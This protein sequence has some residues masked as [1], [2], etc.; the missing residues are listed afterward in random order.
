MAQHALEVD[1]RAVAAQQHQRRD[2]VSREREQPDGQ[3]A[4]GRDVGRARQ[5]RDSAHED[6]YGHDDE[7]DAI[8]QCGE[9]LAAAAAE[10]ASR[11]R[12][13]RGQHAGRERQDYRADIG[14]HV[15]RV[16]QQ[17]ERVEDHAADD[18]GDQHRR[19]DAQ[20]DRHP[21]VIVQADVRV[22]VVCVCVRVTHA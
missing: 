9:D 14:Q 1:V 2:R 11:R 20:G 22:T 21:A 5:P 4:A 10:R 12:R 8:D 3:H 6:E 18:P 16:G 13:P 7:S 19:V 17:R 15:P